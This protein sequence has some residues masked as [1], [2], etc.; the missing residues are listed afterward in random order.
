MVTG[1]DRCNRRRCRRLGYDSVGQGSGGS[2]GDAVVV[3]RST[4]LDAQT[5]DVLIERY[6]PKGR[7]EVAVTRDRRFR[8]GVM[9]PLGHWAWQSS[10]RHSM[11]LS[12][13][14]SARNL[15]ENYLPERTGLSTIVYDFPRRCSKSTCTYT[16]ASS[17]QCTV[18]K[19]GEQ[20]IQRPCFMLFT[21]PLCSACV[22]SYTR[23]HPEPNTCSDPS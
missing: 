3:V 2:S 11:V 16:A 4:A 1:G 21:F 14:M 20:C 5:T 9:R 15:L 22:L 23:R 17:R 8:A 7:M 18:M 13:A 12:L 19:G 10:L 6:K